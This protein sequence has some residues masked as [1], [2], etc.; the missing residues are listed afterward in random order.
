MVTDAEVVTS[1]DS[2][3]RAIFHD[4]GEKWS[5]LGL[6]VHT[7]LILGKDIVNELVSVVDIPTVSQLRL[8]D[9][10]CLKDAFLFL[11]KRATTFILRPVLM[12]QNLITEASR[13]YDDVAKELKWSPQFK[14]KRFFEVHVEIMTT[15]TYTHTGEELEIGARLSW[16][17]SAKCIGR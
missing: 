2:Y 17:N 5:D 7:F 13:F 3:A 14:E 6:S 8:K 10:F 11:Y 15:G 12:H 1:P 4:F 9:A 16:R